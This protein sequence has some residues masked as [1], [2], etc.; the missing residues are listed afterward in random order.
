MIWGA[1]RR[2]AVCDWISTAI[3]AT[4]AVILSALGFDVTAIPLGVALVLLTVMSFAI[5]RYRY[6]RL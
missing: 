6:G 1:L 2:T 5:Y 3:A 4:V